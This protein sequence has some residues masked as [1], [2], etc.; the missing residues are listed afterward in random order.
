MDSR[1]RLTQHLKREDSFNSEYGL[2]YRIKAWVRASLRSL[3]AFS[4]WVDDRS[5]SFGFGALRVA[6]GAISGASG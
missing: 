6:D 3:S 2:R 5:A 4:D 1:F